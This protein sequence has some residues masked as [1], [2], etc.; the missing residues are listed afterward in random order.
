MP[1]RSKLG[2]DDPRVKECTTRGIEFLPND[3]IKDPLI[4]SL[5]SVLPRPD[6]E[7]LTCI[8]R[9]LQNAYIC[10]PR[11][12][13]T[14]FFLPRDQITAI[15]RF[16]QVVSIIQLLECYQSCT[17]AEINKIVEH[18]YCNCLKLLTISILTKNELRPLVED[19]LLDECLPLATEP[20]TDGELL[21]CQTAGHKH[22]YLNNGLDRV[23]RQRISHW[24]YAV[25]APY[26]VRQDT[27][28]I[29]Y[30]LDN[31]DVLPITDIMS[32]E[33]SE[34]PDVQRPSA[35]QGVSQINQGLMGGYGEVK[36]V[37]I[38]PSHFDFKSHDV[39]TPS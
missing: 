27:G 31:N 39:S 38:H 10:Y 13:N 3:R 1:S 36:R 18:I 35:K 32:S 16:D 29:H 20:N 15:M 14:R 30:I 2:L 26:L 25:S 22:T 23:E 11:E 8:R 4:Y 34:A 33:S 6:P 17:A 7:V 9:Q 37:K 19:G 12:S 5:T 21:K 28:H 24:S